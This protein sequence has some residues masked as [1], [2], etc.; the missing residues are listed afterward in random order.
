[1]KTTHDGQNA[2]SSVLLVDVDEGCFLFVG[3]FVSVVAIEAILGSE[4]SKDRPLPF[5]L[6]S[7]TFQI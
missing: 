6:F 1:M 5:S 7:F 3:L 4:Q 2:L